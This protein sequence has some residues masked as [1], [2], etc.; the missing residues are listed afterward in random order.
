MGLLSTHSVFT[1]PYRFYL[2]ITQITVITNSSSALDTTLTTVSYCCAT[3]YPLETS[4]E[5]IG[6]VL[7]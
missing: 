6:I 5:L 4:N 3:L 1:L 2:Q 7:C